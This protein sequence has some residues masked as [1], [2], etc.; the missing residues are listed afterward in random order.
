MENG[1][2]NRVNWHVRR[3]IIFDIFTFPNAISEK[4]RS[5]KIHVINS[6]PK[7]P[8]ADKKNSLMVD[9]FTSYSIKRDKIC[10]AHFTLLIME[11]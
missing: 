5:T 2:S 3:C 9:I 6:T 4:K 1:K 10:F 11:K 8:F 7:F